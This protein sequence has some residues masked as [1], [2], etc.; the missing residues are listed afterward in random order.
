MVDVS[1]FGE[2]MKLKVSV[3]IATSLDGYIARSDGGIDWL[4][5]ANATVPPGE[6]CGF[7]AMMQSVDALVMGRN[8]YEQVLTFG[9][10]VYG[11]TPVTVLSS[12]PLASSDQTPATVKHSSE[13][14]RELCERLA[15]EGIGHIYVDG[16]NTI[17]RF[18]AENLVDELTVTLIPVVLGKGISLFGPLGKDIP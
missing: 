5:A 12:K 18:L 15:G 16:G 9:D 2:M 14:P 6:D 8:T 10:W 4:D 11:D 13:S 3:F 7:G 17:Q 1:P